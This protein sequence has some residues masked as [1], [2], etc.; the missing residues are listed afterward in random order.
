MEVGVDIKP[1]RDAAFDS[2]LDDTKWKIPLSAAD[3]KCVR[4]GPEKKKLR[5]AGITRV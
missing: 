1:G 3:R 5:A 2:C 4:T